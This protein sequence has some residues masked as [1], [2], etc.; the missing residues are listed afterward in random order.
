M[1]TCNLFLISLFGFSCERRAK[2]IVLYCVALYCA[3]LYCTVLYG[4]VLYRLSCKINNA[5]FQ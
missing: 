3:A 4:T 2:C 5:V 1:M